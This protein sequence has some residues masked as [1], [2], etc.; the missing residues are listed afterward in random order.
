MQKIQN[1]DA[2]CSNILPVQ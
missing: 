1:E 2:K